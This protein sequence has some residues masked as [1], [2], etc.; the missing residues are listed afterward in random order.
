MEREVFETVVWHSWSNR[1]YWPGRRE[2]E[3][4]PFRAS[5]KT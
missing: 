4:L 3:T 5:D 2:F 1:H